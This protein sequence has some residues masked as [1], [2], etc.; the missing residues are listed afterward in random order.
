M[1]AAQIRTCNVVAQ[2]H[3]RLSL[4]LHRTSTLSHSRYVG[5]ACKLRA[6]CVKAACRLLERSVLPGQIRGGKTSKNSG[7][8]TQSGE[9]VGPTVAAAAPVCSREVARRYGRAH[10]RPAPQ[11]AWPFEPHRLLSRQLSLGAARQISCH[12]A[13]G[14]VAPE[15]TPDRR[16][17]TVLRVAHLG[18]SIPQAQQYVLVLPR[19]EHRCT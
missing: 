8:Q 1:R 15:A 16:C 14:R 18:S 12:G 3:P 17:R 2:E 5:T 7:D 6:S 10:P 19:A 9:A 4:L 13:S 11:T